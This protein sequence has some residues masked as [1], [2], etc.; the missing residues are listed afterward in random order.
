MDLEWRQQNDWIHT[1][2]EGQLLEPLQ[3]IKYCGQRNI[4]EKLISSAEAAQIHFEQENVPNLDRMKAIQPN[5]ALLQ[6]VI[7]VD[8]YFPNSGMKIFDFFCR[9]WI[10]C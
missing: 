6:R 4:R 3:A 10:H 8:F 9:T 2:D 5:A 1:D 7:D